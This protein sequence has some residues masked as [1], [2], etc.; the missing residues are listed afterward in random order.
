MYSAHK[1]PVD[2]VGYA[3]KRSVLLFFL[4]ETSKGQF[5]VTKQ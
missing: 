4:V 2:T 1:L 5:D 3:P